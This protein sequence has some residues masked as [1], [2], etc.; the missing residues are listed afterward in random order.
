VESL[1]EGLGGGEK[2]R[3]VKV[4]QQAPAK[5]RLKIMSDP[6]NLASVRQAIEG[7]CA[8][9][10]FGT[11]CC[12]EIGLCVNEALANVIRH[13][14]EGATDKPVEVSAEII[15]GSVQIA[16]RDWGNGVNP[17]HL[18]HPPHNPLKP[19]GLGLICLKQMMH[20]VLFTPQPDGML[21][22]MRRKK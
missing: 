6:T 14:Y 12:E 11:K 20:Q 16:I 7:L 13:A 15:D 8:G 19:G 10:G 9:S 3:R 21:L 2:A 1:A 4:T 18:P 5:L 22:E 17:D